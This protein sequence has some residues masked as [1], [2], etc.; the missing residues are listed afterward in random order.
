MKD[1]VI[2]LKDSDYYIIDELEYK[3]K[4]YIMCVECNFDQSEVLSNYIIMELFVKDN[5]I[6]VDD[7]KDFEIQSIV[8]NLFL[9]NLKN[10]F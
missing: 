5:K 10:I 6:M 1:K 4:K 7:I 8:N 3:E 9:A 2:R